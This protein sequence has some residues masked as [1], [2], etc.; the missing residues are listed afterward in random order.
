MNTKTYHSVSVKAKEDRN[1][2]PW[3]HFLQISY[4][5]AKNLANGVSPRLMLCPF[6]DLNKKKSTIL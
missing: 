4:W 3:N 5:K 2:I 6:E 1:Q